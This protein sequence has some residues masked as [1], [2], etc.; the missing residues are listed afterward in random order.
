MKALMRLGQNQV[1][2]KMIKTSDFV[3]NRDLLIMAGYKR[4][5]IL[6]IG[7]AGGWGGEA[8]S[9]GYAAIGPGKYRMMACGPGGGGTLWLK[10]LLSYLPA[11]PAGVIGQPG[12]NA[13][14]GSADVLSQNGTDGGSTTFNGFSAYGGQGGQGGKYVST[15]Y[16]DGI[17]VDKVDITVRS[18]GGNGGGNSVGL[19]GMG[20]GGLIHMREF[21][22][23]GNLVTTEA[24]NPTDGTADFNLAYNPNGGAYAGGYGGGGG[25]GQNML[26]NGTYYS[27][28]IPGGDGGVPVY[29]GDPYFSGSGTPYDIN[30]NYRPGGCGGGGSFK[31]LDGET[32]EYGGSVGTLQ[33]P[34]GAIWVSLS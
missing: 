22:N 7:A 17:N 20:E 19:G 29:V 14:Q 30:P 33:N 13:P 32:L 27:M 5:D 4:Y 1:P 3:L 15:I 16:N 9:R 26:Y 31:D 11:F 12:V 23:S 28:A 10:G 2:P 8:L 18:R 25:Q 6:L 34:G 24:V 21:N